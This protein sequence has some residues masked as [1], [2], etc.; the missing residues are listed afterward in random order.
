MVQ[1]KR[2]KRCSYK[3]CPRIIRKHNKSGLCNNHIKK[4][5]MKQKVM[6]KELNK[7]TSQNDKG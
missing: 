3:G 5:H 2:C 1:T 4:K 6:V 7:T